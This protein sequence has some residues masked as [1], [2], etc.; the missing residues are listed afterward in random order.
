MQ[1]ARS[2]KPSFA[3]PSTG[4]GRCCYGTIANSGSAEGEQRYFATTKLLLG[5]EELDVKVQWYRAPCL[6]NL[7]DSLLGIETRDH[8]VD[9]FSTLY[10]L[11]SMSCTVGIFT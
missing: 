11:L 3:P 4:I 8:E 1:G 2:H 5:G 6:L 9:T 10:L 7:L